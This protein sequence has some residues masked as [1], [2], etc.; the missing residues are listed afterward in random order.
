MAGSIAKLNIMLG[1]D[2]SGIISGIDGTAV[3]KVRE[4]KNVVDNLSTG[5]ATSGAAG[6]RSNFQGAN[7][8]I[9]LMQGRLG[10]IGPLMANLSGYALGI[11]AAFGAARFAAF[12]IRE[13]GAQD[14]EFVSKWTQFKE[15]IADLAMI[16]GRF[17]LPPLKEWL[18]VGIAAIQAMKGGA[19]ASVTRES[20]RR[21]PEEIDKQMKAIT[22]SINKQN[23]AWSELGKRITNE[24]RTPGEVL[25]QKVGELNF[26][27]NRGLITFE[28]YSRAINKAADEF[29]EMGEKAKVFK[30]ITS[31]ENAALDRF[32][33][34]GF[35]ATR[36]AS[37]KWQQ[38]KD[39][40]QRQ[41]E[42]DKLA[43]RKRDEIL[44][45]IRE[46]GTRV[47]EVTF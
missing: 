20:L 17:L 42:E 8:A 30:Q 23:E 4:F 13:A 15:E 46:G 33:S 16:V 25:N 10:A 35:S 6:L 5:S 43:N 21:G 28:T 9:G 24:F 11:A 44:K 45:A 36:E 38:L 41:L 22:D 40:Q 34:A 31:T 27:A 14:S 37:D 12:A 47:S 32:T 3:P 18:T 26:L 39:I 29:A 2:T 19:A 7:A 1:V